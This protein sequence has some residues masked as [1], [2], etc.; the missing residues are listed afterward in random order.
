[1]IDTG[2]GLDSLVQVG[3]N[4]RL[5]RCCVVVAQV[6]LAGSKALR[7][8]VQVGGQA[9]IAGHIRIGPGARIGV[10][11]GVMSDLPAAAAVVG[12]PAQARREF[13][14]QVVVLKRIARRGD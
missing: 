3:H 2:S 14:R 10:Q 1:M 7:D 5:G 6:G 9:V 4:F 12:S 11:V 8:F 13:F